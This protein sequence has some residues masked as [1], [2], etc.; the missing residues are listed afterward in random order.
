MSVPAA[1]QVTIPEPIRLLVEGTGELAD[2][3]ALAGAAHA[4]VEFGS[5]APDVVVFCDPPALG[6][7]EAEL[8]EALQRG[9]H[10]ISTS[11]EL[12]A[13]RANGDERA[14]AVHSAAMNA[15]RSVIATGGGFG[16]LQAVLIPVLTL[17][18]I[19]RG[20]ITVTRLSKDGRDGESWRLHFQGN[21][22][23]EAYLD[24]EVSG[25]AT[26][27]R[28]MVNLVPRVITAP[29]GLHLVGELPPITGW[30]PSMPGKAEATR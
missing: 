13:A 3:L 19:D 12:A 11:D 21:P 22:E 20:P 24:G 16:F 18:T 28:L 7:H 26:V 17:A 1:A 10:A 8:V 2:E 4:G 14:L 25:T 29:A 23:I 5:R 30:R 6:E 27:A 15:G 9:A